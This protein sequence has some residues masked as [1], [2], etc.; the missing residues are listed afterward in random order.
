MKMMKTL[1]NIVTIAR[2]QQREE[3]LEKQRNDPIGI[4][5][6]SLFSSVALESVPVALE[7][8]PIPLILETCVESFCNAAVLGPRDPVYKHIVVHSF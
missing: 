4:G 2:Q 3:S 8:V 1:S 7:S 6:I 5:V